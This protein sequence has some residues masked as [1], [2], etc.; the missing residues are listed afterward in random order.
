M[1]VSAKKLLGSK[2]NT[3][4]VAVLQGMRV[5]I[6]V[7]DG[8]L[9]SELLEPKRLLSMQVR[10]RSLC[11]RSPTGSEEELRGMVRKMFRSIFP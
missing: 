2:E 5:A 1:S 7:R 3:M 11:A 8:F 6:L 4:T 10:L 9:E